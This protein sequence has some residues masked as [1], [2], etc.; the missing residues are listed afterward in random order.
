MNDYT[1]I[2]NPKLSYVPSHLQ[3]KY[4]YC[5]NLNGTKVPLG[6]SIQ[7]ALYTNPYV[8]GYVKENNTWYLYTR[9][10]QVAIGSD[11]T[12]L[13][14]TLLYYPNKEDFMDVGYGFTSFRTGSIAII[15][16]QGHIFNVLVDSSD[17]WRCR[18]ISLEPIVNKCN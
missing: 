15:T 11:D 10:W 14:S 18:E 9:E 8:I 5:V 7:N 16:E 17:Y 12:D 4:A 13:E 1:D 2:V 3:D 6:K